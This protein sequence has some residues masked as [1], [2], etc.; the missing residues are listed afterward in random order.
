MLFL[1]SSIL[2]VYQFSVLELSVQSLFTLSACV[3]LLNTFLVA[4]PAVLEVLIHV[5]LE[6]L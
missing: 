6:A 2:D 1:R 3:H 5:I 4:M